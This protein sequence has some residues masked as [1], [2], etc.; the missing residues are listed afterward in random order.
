MK[1]WNLLMSNAYA[2]TAVAG[3]AAVEGSASV[4]SMIISM[5]PMVLIIDGNVQATNLMQTG[6]DLQWL[7]AQLAPKNLLPENVFFACLDTQGLMTVQPMEG[8]CFSFSAL[9]ASEVSW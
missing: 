6:R 4:L 9:N 3:E 8:D 5:L 1:L 7:S 2:E